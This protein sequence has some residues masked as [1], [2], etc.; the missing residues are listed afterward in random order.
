MAFLRHLWLDFLS[1]PFTEKVDAN[2]EAKLVVQALR[3]NTLSKLTFSD[4]MRF[5]ALLKDIF[6]GMWFTVYLLDKYQ[7]MLAWWD[8]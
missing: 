1:L 7:M 3:I 6:P 2:T 5:D 4:S 8:I